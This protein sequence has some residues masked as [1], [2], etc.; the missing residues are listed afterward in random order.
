MDYNVAFRL[1]KK[2]KLKEVISLWNLRFMFFLYK[3]L[4]K[5]RK[6]YSKFVWFAEKNIID[7]QSLSSKLYQS[8]IRIISG[9]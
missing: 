5:L 2:W 6:Y 9:R 7:I 8:N 1:E 4:K 3:L